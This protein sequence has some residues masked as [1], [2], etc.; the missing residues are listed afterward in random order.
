LPAPSMTTGDSAGYL[1]ADTVQTVFDRA[2]LEAYRAA[3]V[4]RA[5]AD[6]KWAGGPGAE[7]MPGDVVTFSLISALAVATTPLNES[8]EPSP[9]NIADTQTT[10]SL[11]EYGNAV[12]TT[13]KFRL[14]SFLNLDLTIPREVGAN[15]E[16]SVDIVA[17]DVLVAGSNV[18]YG[19]DAT[20]RITL[21]TAATA[22]T[23]AAN[24]VRR[25]RAFLAGRNTPPPPGSPMYVGFI[26]PDVD[27]DLQAESGQ[28]AWSAPHVY[29]DPAAIYSG[30]V[31]AL[32]GVRFV[33]NANAKI[34]A[35]AGSGSPG[36]FMDVYATIFVGQQA[37]GEAVGESQHMVLS[38]PFDDL[39]RFMSVGWYGLLGYGRVREN[40][41]LRYETVSS[42][43]A[44]TT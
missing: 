6:V 20:S 23:L 19:G 36:G 2:A 11:V 10:I 27:Y 25:A 18:L 28:Q 17:R 43:G 41:L 35:N 16:E 34:W 40:S 31:G 29:S 22:D 4:Y 21:S 32:S 9:V 7:P 1:G 13:K 37:L 30:E 24:N 39:Q 15:M 42:I 3:N 26:H 38:G 8:T 44:N 33:E 14:T 12:K 5:V